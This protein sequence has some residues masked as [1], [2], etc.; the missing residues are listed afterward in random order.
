M[1]VDNCYVFWVPLE[2]VG[3]EELSFCCLDLKC[4][5][6]FGMFGGLLQNYKHSFI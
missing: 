1:V 2:Q 3:A 6:H 5:C 4:Y